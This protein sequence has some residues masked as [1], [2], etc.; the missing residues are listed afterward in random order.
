[1]E[2]PFRRV[3]SPKELL[4]GSARWAWLLS[5]VS[6]LSLCGLLFGV[7]LL[8]DLLV[9]RGEVLLP[10]EVDSTAY[11]KLTETLPSVPPAAQGVVSDNAPVAQHRFD[12]GL[13]VTVWAARQESWGSFVRALVR[14]IPALRTTNSALLTLLATNIALALLSSLSALQ[15]KTLAFRTSPIILTQRF[16][17]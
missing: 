16:G 2:T 6:A 9:T 4:R 7:C 17:K 14:W 15:I 5:A 11:E 8:V 13:R 10:T 3:F 12:Q 1:M